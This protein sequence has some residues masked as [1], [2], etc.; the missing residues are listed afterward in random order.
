MHI[1]RQQTEESGIS[2]PQ[3]SLWGPLRL[4]LLAVLG[5]S[6]VWQVVTRTL[7][8]YLANVD[9]HTALS[10]RSTEPRALLNLADARLNLDPPAKAAEPASPALATQPSPDKAGAPP[11][12][13]DRRPSWA[14]IASK[15]RDKEGQSGQLRRPDKPAGKLEPSAA[16]GPSGSDQVRAWAEAALAN[17]PLSAQAFRILGQL[18]DGAGDEKRT[19][20]LM[21]GAVRRSIRESLAVYWLMRK[22]LEDRD[23]ATT[24]YCADALLR[25]RPQLITHVL[26]ILVQLAD[27]KDASGELKKLL[28]GSP[29]WR[30]QFFAALPHA[31]TDARTPL[32]LL[33]AVKDTPSPPTARDLQGYLNV[34]IQ[35]KLYELAYYVWLQFLPPEQL[36]KVG[37]LFNGS[38]EMTPSGLAFDW[39]IA[40]GAGV[41]IDIAR[42]P[43]QEGQ[44]ALFI[45]FGQGRVDFPGVSQLTMLAPGTYRFKA[46]YKGEIVGRRGLKWRVTCVGG[47]R[48][49][50]GE[51]PMISGAT[52]AWSDLEFAFT[53]PGADCRAQ[54]LRLELDAR[55]A[56]EQLV[57]GSVWHDELL[58]A[59]EP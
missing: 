6:L 33:L 23:Y 43:D 35:H 45:E 29:P 30:S 37:L 4:F 18:A 9:P 40:Q 36:T 56:S 59:R 13:T 34:L 50:I 7:V 14:E 22:S 24:L 49:P 44:R 2:E 5:A 12:A 21:Q 54:H 8:A 28:V 46:S 1:D 48:T 10:L 19:S 53:V 57:S 42:H 16:S 39:L 26:P 11:P 3:R 38:F 52:P 27:T 47:G 17:E 20:K 32:E 15:V 31:I 51:S 25:T 41:T 55:M 58:L